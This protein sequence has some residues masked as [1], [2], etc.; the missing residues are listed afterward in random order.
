MGIKSKVGYSLAA[1][2]G[3]GLGI[4]AQDSLRNSLALF[5]PNFIESSKPFAF[6]AGAAVTIYIVVIAAKVI[7][8][9]KSGEITSS[10]E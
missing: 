9:Y 4:Y 5:G 7:K 3:G 1:L 8:G 10:H 6:L 2:G